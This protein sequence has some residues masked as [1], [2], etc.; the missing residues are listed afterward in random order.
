MAYASSHVAAAVN[1]WRRASMAGQ[2][3][4]PVVWSE[5]LIDSLLKEGPRHLNT[6]LRRHM[7]RLDRNGVEMCTGMLR[8]LDAYGTLSRAI[9]TARRK[10]PTS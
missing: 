9:T 5:V 4:L 2:R 1:A 7:M 8:A 6:A 3:L 10:E